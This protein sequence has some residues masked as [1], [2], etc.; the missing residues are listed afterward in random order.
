ME[1]ERAQYL[2]AKLSQYADTS[3]NKLCCNT[4][5]PARKPS[6]V[7][8]RQHQ[9]EHQAVSQCAN[10]SKNTNLCHNA[11]T[12]ARTPSCVTMRQHQQEHQ[13]V[14]QC[15]DTSKN[16]K[17]CH[18]APTPAGTPS[19]VTMRRHQQEHQAVSQCADTAG[20]PSCVTMHR[21]SRNT[22]LCHNAPT[23]ARTPSCVTMHRHQQEHQAV[24][25]C[26]DTARTPSCVTMHRHSRNT[27]L[28]HNAPTQQEHQAV[29][30]C[31]DTA[32]TPSCVTMHRHS[33]NTKLCHNAPTQQ[34][35]QAVSQCA[36]TAGT[37]RLHQNT[38][39]RC[40][41]MWGLSSATISPLHNCIHPPEIGITPPE[42]SVR[43]FMC[44]GQK[45]QPCTQSSNPT[46]C[47]CQC[48]SAC[49][50]RRLEWSVGPTTTIPLE[51]RRQR[52]VSSASCGASWWTPPPCGTAGV[53]PA[54]PSAPQSACAEDSN[55]C[56][57]TTPK[58]SASFI[59]S[60]GNLSLWCQSKDL[61]HIQSNQCMVQG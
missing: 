7:A 9:Q 32:G 29:S 49:T 50:R 27:K 42:D 1:Y 14:S 22:K 8:T 58:I 17:L 52:T 48:T 25:Q 15:T 13:A 53:P 18:N 34:E 21:H 56:I 19:C 41:V 57:K 55:P 11:P 6:C 44:R 54:S 2:G 39:V 38:V 33:R 35:H 47:I 12:P 28:C 23:P 4:P 26:T 46:E 30:Q 51:H 37:P 45:K 5:T 40:I 24:S 3:K 60:A 20:T 36:D 61:S 31:T 16:T 59:S 43:L 10:T